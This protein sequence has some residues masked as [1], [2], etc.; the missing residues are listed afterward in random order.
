MKRKKFSI[1]V[2][3]FMLVFVSLSFTSCGESGGENDGTYSG[4]VSITGKL[5]APDGKTPIAGAAVYIPASS[6][7]QSVK[8]VV[9]QSILK[10]ETPPEKYI[11]FSCTNPDGSFSL[12]FDNVSGN[13]VIIKFKKGVFK[14]TL[15][16][17]VS[18]SDLSLGNVSI[19]SNPTDG[20]PKI[21]VVTG[22]YDSM[23]IVLAKLG[24]GSINSW[25]QLE[26]GTEK[27]DLYDGNY[28]LNDNK[29]PNFDALFLDLDSDGKPDIYNY[30][31][32]FIN[33]GNNYEYD[34]LTD[35]TKISI[36]REYVNQG[37][38]LYITDLSYDF[39][40][41]VFPEFL[42]FYGSDTTPESSQEVMGAAE[43]GNA[44]ITAEAD[45]L[46]TTL[47][48]WLE[49]V[50]CVDILGNSVKCINSSTNTV[51][52]EGF[53]S[54]W[55]VINGPHPTHNSDVKIWVE[56]NVSWWDGSDQNGVKPLTVSFSVGKGKVLYTSYH[57]EASLGTSGLLPQERILQYLVFF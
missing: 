24:F 13:K 31:I 44:G 50:S 18:S 1:V 14:K 42:D 46:D 45:V 17:D 4:N 36:L 55:A 9:K 41:Q 52:I 12:N 15:T 30:D 2:S 54:G 49:T 8:T 3:F 23:E 29:Y 10:C 11:A 16:L 38:R 27:F 51:H 21:A 56:G 19:P 43:V 32:V 53:L 22:N 26:Y 39:V 48:K 6:S 37:G 7:Q 35:T 57:T 5:L 34:V 40:E 25:G 20:A 47:A 28:S 33:C